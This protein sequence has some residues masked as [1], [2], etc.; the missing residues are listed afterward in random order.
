M[1]RGLS[2]LEYLGSWACHDDSQ[3]HDMLMFN[4]T[5]AVC[6]EV[7][8]SESPPHLDLH[9]TAVYIRHSNLSTLIIMLTVTN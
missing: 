6:H 7:I 4:Y 1:S 8:F 2:K 3:A 5:T 9:P